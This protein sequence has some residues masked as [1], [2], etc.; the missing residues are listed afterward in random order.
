MQVTAVVLAAGQSSRMGRPKQLAE[1]GGQPMITRAVQTA[2]A[3]GAD[4]VLVVVGAYRAAVT[5][6]LQPLQAAAEQRLGLVEN[7]HFA[8]GQASSLHAAI[9]A[10][11]EQT[12]AAL[13]LPVDQPFLTP[14]LL[15]RLIAA[16]RAGAPLAASAV[17]GAV[18]G[19][20]AIFDRSLWPELLALAG[21]EGARPLLR[22]YAQALV[23]VVADAAELRDI[24]TPEELAAAQR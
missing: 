8:S 19:A 7:P 17:N 18:R 3:S 6:A 10:L 11:D 14:T 1:V 16:W 12:G 15:Q 4:E 2:L 5:A 21:D 22:K 20:P 9:H 23:P 13:F 24:D